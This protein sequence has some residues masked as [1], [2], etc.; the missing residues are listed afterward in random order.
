MKSDLQIERK[1]R[2][3][4]F[5]VA[6][7]SKKVFRWAKNKMTLIVVLIFIQTAANLIH[8]NKRFLNDGIDQDV[9]GPSQVAAVTVFRC[10]D[11]TA[12]KKSEKEKKTSGITAGG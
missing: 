6:F 5:S 9:N 11:A 4:D 2:T 3:D 10:C 1:K 7:N 8:L 12:S